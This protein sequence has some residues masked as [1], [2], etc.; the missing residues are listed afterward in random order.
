MNGQP[1]TLVV[2]CRSGRHRSV[3]FA[4][5]FSEWVVTLLQYDAACDVLHLSQNRQ[6]GGYCST[7]SDCTG[8]SPVKH[9][10]LQVAF[11][12]FN[13]LW[14]DLMPAI[15]R[16]PRASGSTRDRSRSP[17]LPGPLTPRRCPQP[18]GPPTPS[19]RPPPSVDATAMRV[20]HR[21]QQ[22]LAILPQEGLV[23][24]RDVVL[25]MLAQNGPVP[26]STPPPSRAG[27]REPINQVRAR[28]AAGALAGLGKC[29]WPWMQ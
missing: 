16:A 23:M 5:I 7:C 25:G 11:Q 20:V 8:R 19:R 29:T 24:I 1:V 21:V 3:S 28:D 13:G 12:I 10:T 26:P 17:H 18:L 27:H 6:W 22:D 14:K 15:A 4:E 9:E 2:A